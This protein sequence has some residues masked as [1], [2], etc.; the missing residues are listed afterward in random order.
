MFA[1]VADL[2]W[3]TPGLRLRLRLACVSAACTGCSGHEEVCFGVFAV[4][5]AFAVALLTLN[6]GRL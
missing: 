4:K 6:M 1:A 2:G 3:K 5:A